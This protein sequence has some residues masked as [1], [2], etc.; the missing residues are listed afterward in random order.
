MTSAQWEQLIGTLGTIGITLAQCLG[1]VFASNLAPEMSEALER[2]NSDA[3]RR[4]VLQGL[5]LARAEAPAKVS[6][7]STAFESYSAG[8]RTYIQASREVLPSAAQSVCAAGSELLGALE[9]AFWHQA[10]NQG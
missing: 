8:L 10:L 2:L 4:A 3:A 9:R 1:G 6:A 7:V 5:M